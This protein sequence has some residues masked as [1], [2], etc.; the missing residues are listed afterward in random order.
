[1]SNQSILE[2][3]TTAAILAILAILA[4]NM[5][6]IDLMSFAAAILAAI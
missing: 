2:L 4:A 3:A 1:M 6:G 5:I